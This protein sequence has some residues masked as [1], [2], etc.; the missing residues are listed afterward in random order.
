[1]LARPAARARLASGNRHRDGRPGGTRAST[2]P[3]MMHGL[4]V[5][6]AVAADSEAA[7]EKPRPSPPLHAGSGTESGPRV[8]MG[9]R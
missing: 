6:V 4:L 7:A 1:M 2:Y 9:C 8:S 3:M 5:T